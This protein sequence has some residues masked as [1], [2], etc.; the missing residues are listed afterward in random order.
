MTFEQPVQKGKRSGWQFASWGLLALQLA[1]AIAALSVT[2]AFE[3]VY[4]NFGAS[5]PAVQVA[6]VSYPLVWWCFPLVGLALA[7][8]CSVGFSA[9]PQATR[10]PI[11]WQLV[12]TALMVASM[13]F[14]LM[15]LYVP[16]MALGQ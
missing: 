11:V 8:W 4:V 13:A 12:W 1:L 7:V 10:K 5:L 16:I 9:S 2:A 14:G 15:A 3:E 6:L